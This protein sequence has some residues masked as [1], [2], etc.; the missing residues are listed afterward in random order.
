[1]AYV[2]VLALW[3]VCG[4]CAVCVW[5]VEPAG[6][7]VHLLRSA[8]KWSLGVEPEES[9]HKA[10]ADAILGARHFVYI[11]NQFFISGTAGQGVRN[12]IG[13]AIVDRISRAIM[14]K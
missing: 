7:S 6:C 5:W 10:L 9:I 4:V 2:C 1:M 11:E 12:C 13:Q 8:S 14:A 3:C